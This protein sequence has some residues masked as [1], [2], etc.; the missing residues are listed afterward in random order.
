MWRGL[1]SPHD[2]ITIELKS[3]VPVPLTR[4]RAKMSAQRSLRQSGY[5]AD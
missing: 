2:N 1:A 5:P 3:A 4:G